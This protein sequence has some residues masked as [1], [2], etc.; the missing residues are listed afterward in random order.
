[1][2]WLPCV[3]LASNLAA[4][5]QQDQITSDTGYLPQARANAA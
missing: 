5:L 1:M 2:A 3:L 4:P